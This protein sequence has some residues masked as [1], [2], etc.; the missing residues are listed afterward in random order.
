MYL[1]PVRMRIKSTNNKCWRRHREK[2]TLLHCWWEC[3]LVQPL[4]NTVW[5]LLKKLNI[6]LP[7]DSPI[8]LPDKTVIQKDSCTPLFLVVLFTLAK[9]LH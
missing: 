2:E 1:I 8:P 9:T 6:E 3:K 5:R 7:Y 4:W